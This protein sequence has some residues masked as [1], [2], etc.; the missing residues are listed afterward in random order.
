MSNIIDSWAVF[1]KRLAEKDREISKLQLE[2]QD[3]DF[4]TQ[5]AEFRAQRV[6]GRAR[7]ADIAEARAQDLKAQLRDCQIRLCQ[8][9]QQIKTLTDP[10]EEVD[11]PSS[12]RGSWMT[13]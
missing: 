3:A 9:E 13:V 1:N 12:H 4:H 7:D 2:K 10:L 5:Q 11:Y 6:E 8:A